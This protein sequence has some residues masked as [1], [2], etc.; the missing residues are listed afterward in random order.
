MVLLEV[1]DPDATSDE[2]DGL[3]GIGS[4]LVGCASVSRPSRKAEFR[5]RGFD[6]SVTM[7]E[8]RGIVAKV[9]G[10]PQTRCLVRD[11]HAAATESPG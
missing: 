2:V 6:P 8:L 4:A 1:L 10:A 3:A 5:L 7:E 11:A 9:A